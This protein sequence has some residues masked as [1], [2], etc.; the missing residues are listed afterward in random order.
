MTSQALPRYPVGMK[1][2]LMSLAAA[3]LPLVPGLALAQNHSA[4]M[5]MPGSQFPI[6]Q[7]PTPISI[8]VPGL[9]LPMPSLPGPIPVRYDYLPNLHTIVPG[10][11]LPGTIPAGVLASAAKRGSGLA[12]A[13]SAPKPSAARFEKTLEILRDQFGLEA[14]GTLAK[15]AKAETASAT[16][17]GSAKAERSTPVRG[18]RPVQSIPERELERDLGIK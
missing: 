16:F 1:K 6:I 2:I 18:D 17:D 9:P 3:T 14:D 11:P 8:P 15:D 7:V 10:V 13:A 4:V 5:R 12:V